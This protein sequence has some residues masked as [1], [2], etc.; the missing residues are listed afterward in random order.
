M[1]RLESIAT[2]F[3]RVT[4]LDANVIALT[5][6][7]LSH[8]WYKE[9]GKP[10]PF[11]VSE[12]TTSQMA[13]AGTHKRA[14][15]PKAF[16]KDNVFQNKH[17]TFQKDPPRIIIT[18]F[19][20]QRKQI[21]TL[22]IAAPIEDVRVS[23]SKEGCMV[24]HFLTNDAH[25]L[26]WWVCSEDFDARLLR[27]HEVAFVHQAKFASAEHIVFRRQFVTTFCVLH[28]PTKTV[29]PMTQFRFMCS[30]DFLGTCSIENEGFLAIATLHDLS[31][32]WKCQGPEVPHL[33]WTAP[34]GMFNH[35]RIF[36]RDSRFLI[37]LGIRSWIIDMSLTNDIGFMFQHPKE[38][39]PCLLSNK[40]VANICCNSHMLQILHNP[41]VSTEPHD[42][43]V[44]MKDQSRT[45]YDQWQNIVV[46]KQICIQG[47]CTLQEVSP[48]VILVTTPKYFQQFD[49]QSHWEMTSHIP[50]G[51]AGALEST[52]PQTL[53]LQDQRVFIGSC[54]FGS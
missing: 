18:D 23:I 5:L 1:V 24:I 45:F 11:Y 53:I 4:P 46:F 54:V 30:S 19:E 13:L 32:V 34:P 3:V 16:V 42:N 15:F 21:L 27:F 20:Q 33:L 49:L 40:R 31:S 9:F 7:Y 37:T 39:Q 2:L 44:V 47:P 12:Q 36:S 17:V 48:Q 10:R 43:G 51:L 41:F 35:V 38:V 29:Q 28:A 25:K 14:L 6:M 50:S 52:V 8:N 22:P 26:C